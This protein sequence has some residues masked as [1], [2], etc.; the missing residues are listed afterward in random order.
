[1]GKWILFQAEKNE[2]G[3]GMGHNWKHAHPFSHPHPLIKMRRNQ[4]EKERKKEDKKK[5][6]SQIRSMLTA[7]QFKT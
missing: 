1:M 2:I 5:D 6:C 7:T 3:A 4:R